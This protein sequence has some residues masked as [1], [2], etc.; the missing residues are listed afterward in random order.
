M[1]GDDIMSSANVVSGILYQKREDVIYYFGLKR[2]NETLLAENLRLRAEIAAMKSID[3]LK[4]SV[5]TRARSTPGDSGIVVTYAAY[6]FRAARVI[7]NSL[8]AENNFI[9]I[10]R[11][12]LDGVRKNMAVVSS[13]GI[14]GRVVNVSDHFA[15]ILSVL[16]TKQQVNA[17]LK[18]GTL[19]TVIWEAGNP[20]VFILKDIPP[21]IK[22][23]RGDSVFSTNYSF[24]PPDVLI[25]RVVK[26]EI[27][28]KNN[29]QLIH[30]KTATNFRNL[31]FV[32]VVENKMIE[33]QKKLEATSTQ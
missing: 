28:R 10:N 23:S 16:S 15:S 31:Q 21:Q 24:F 17:R 22:V 6:R 12:L 5:A 27:V 4:D 13:A 3:T 29:L 8:S 1:Q 14:V 11:G 19:G 25:G 33:E 26:T 30:L 7:N 9:T 18:D 2:M 32:Y 20:D